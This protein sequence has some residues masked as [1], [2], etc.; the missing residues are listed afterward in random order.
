MKTFEIFLTALV[1]LVAKARS[2]V[3]YWNTPYG[4]SSANDVMSYSQNYQSDI[5]D[6]YSGGYAAGMATNAISFYHCEKYLGCYVECTARSVTLTQ[7]I[8]SHA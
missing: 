1:I 3:N 7:I 4:Y 5:K 8:D 2:E 6:S